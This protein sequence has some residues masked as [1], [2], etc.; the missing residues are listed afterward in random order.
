MPADFEY[1][2]TTYGVPACKN[3]RVVING[4]PGII[5]RDM[6][7]HIGV[8]MDAGP[9]DR[10][11]PAHPTWEVVYGEIGTPRKVKN[12]RNKD[13]YQRYRDADFW[14]GSFLDFCYWD[15]EQRRKERYA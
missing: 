1:V 10:V 2:R 3:R 4:E 8:I 15:A 7:H 6:G 11:V 14:S 12:R 13:R 5:A 9:P